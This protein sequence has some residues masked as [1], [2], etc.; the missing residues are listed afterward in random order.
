MAASNEVV[1][2]CAARD[3]IVA[4][5]IKESICIAESAVAAM[6]DAAIAFV[7]TVNPM[8]LTS[9]MFPQVVTLGKE[10][11]KAELSG[12][13]NLAAHFGNVTLLALAKDMPISFEVDRTVQGVKGK[14]EVQT[15]GTEATKL[16]KNDASIAAKTVREDIGIERA[17]GGGRTPRT[18][19]ATL[20]VFSLV[21][22]KAQLKG[23][24]TSSGA[25]EV[26]RNN[27]E[28]YGVEVFLAGEI[29][30]KNDEIKALKVALAKAKKAAKK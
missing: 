30:A 16:S 22:F 1:S 15:T 10:L 14:K 8:G 20:S 9:A 3:E 19:S 4:G 12:N 5:K 17:E 18:P 6:R 13:N 11:Y 28:E 7:A 24:F 27:L 25:V 23:L 21:E 29:R 2:K 26:V